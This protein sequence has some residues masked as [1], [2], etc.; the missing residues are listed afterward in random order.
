MNRVQITIVTY[1]WPPR[2]AIGTHRPYS[3]AKYW[4][5]L[6]A[7]VKILTA[8]KYNFDAPL[9]LILPELPGIE[10]H[11]IPY[12]RRF[13]PAAS[14]FRVPALLSLARRFKSSISQNIGF[15]VDPRQRWFKAAQ[16]IALHLS[17][18]SD[19]VVS[20]F[21]PPASH[22]IACEMKRVNP[23]LRWVADYRDLWSIRHNSNLPLRKQQQAQE[24]E[25]RSVGKYADVLTTVSEELASQLNELFNRSTEVI[26]NG[27]DIS[28]QEL[29]QNLSYRKKENGLPIR[30]VYTG[31]IHRN[32]QDPRPLLEALVSMRENKL[33]GPDD[34]TVDFYGAR[35]DWAKE[36]AQQPRFSPFIRTMGHVPRE[37]ALVAQK[38][39]NLLLLLESGASEA[40]GVLTGKVFEYISSGTPVLSVGSAL[41]SAIDKLLTQTG[42]GVCVQDDIS[43][44]QEVVS[45][46]IENGTPK[47]FKPHIGE[48]MKYSRKHQAQKMFE[49]LF[50]K[51]SMPG[52]GQS[53]R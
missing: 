11:E 28:E 21:G 4:S 38:D 27:F 7:Q 41:N 43:V 18:D 29:R 34:I 22:L 24:T 52:Q 3:W 17:H 19:I 20:T 37:E 9:D 23:E 6:G 5:E 10:V 51:D 26:T 16:P 48:F 36:L 14:T 49:V 45:D 44:I 35:I 40:K 30:I 2:N 8:K 50:Y 13:S 33:I 31:M 15:N 1:N 47:F 12:M 46:V 39:A 42:C 53:E 32:H 25:R